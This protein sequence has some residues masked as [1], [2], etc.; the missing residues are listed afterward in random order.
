MSP[1]HRLA[2][3][4]GESIYREVALVTLTLY[5]VG[6]RVTSEAL[7]TGAWFTASGRR[8]FLHDE[9]ELVWL[10]EWSEKDHVYRRGRR[11][12]P[13]WGEPSTV[14]AI[15][16]VEAKAPLLQ[17][18]ILPEY[19]GLLDHLLRDTCQDDVFDMG[20]GAKGD[21]GEYETLLAFGIGLLRALGHERDPAEVLAALER[22]HDEALATHTYPLDDAVR[23]RVVFSAFYVVR[24]RP[25]TWIDPAP[26]TEWWLDA[27][28]LLRV[29]EGGDDASFA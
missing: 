21:P 16:A 9:P 2:G 15:Y 14:H 13:P 12:L 25:P 11:D 1:F 10:T 19:G 24:S 3:P 20:G 6:E 4:D 18:V 17:L 7:E 28:C 26:D 5:K 29:P 22:E 8:V 23:S 27:P